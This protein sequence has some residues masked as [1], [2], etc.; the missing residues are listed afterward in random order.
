MT[1]TS[2]SVEVFFLDDMEDEVIIT[3]LNLRRQKLQ[4]DVQFYLDEREMFSA[5]DDRRQAPESLPKLIVTDLNMPGRGGI[6]VVESLRSDERFRD[7]TIGVCTGSDNPA[8]H[9]AAIAAGADFAAVK[10]FDRKT[11][12]HIC[13]RTG[14]FELIQ[15]D[16][17]REHLRQTSMS[18][19]AA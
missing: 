14:R 6:G 16:D 1:T 8:D 7:V 13:E 12:A 2:E 10:P 3:E 15:R 19:H 11:L 9:A 5:L 17:G 18:G 4:L